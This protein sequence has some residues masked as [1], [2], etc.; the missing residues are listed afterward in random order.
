MPSPRETPVHPAVRALDLE[1]VTHEGTAGIVLHDR[2]G[3]SES[4][5]LPEELL[6]IVGR[7]DG[8]HT[9]QQI[10]DEASAQVGEEIPLEF[11]AGLVQQLD[12]RGLLL[13]PTYDGIALAAAERFLA[14]GE[15]PARHAGSAGYPRD[16]GA[17]RH[18]LDQLLPA[19]AGPSGP[20]RGL[21]APHIDLQRGAEG[22]AAA[23]R[24]LLAAPPAD[25]YVVFGTGH[26][27]PDAPVTGLPLDWQTP[28]GTVPT[29]REFV[30]AVHARIGTAAPIDLLH[31]RDEHS[32]EFQMLFLQHLHQRRG[33]ERPFAVAAFL[34]G[35]LPS[36]HGDPLAEDWCQDLLRAF[37]AAEAASG[38]TVC[39][40]AGADLAHIGPVFGDEAAVDQ[41]R[42]S[43]LA[44]IEQARLRHLQ[45][46]A[47]GAFHAAVDCDRNPDRIC[48]GPAITLCAALAG[49][50]GELL[51]Y[52][53][54]AA[55]DGSQ[56]VSF[57]A[58]AFAGG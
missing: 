52:G 11:V 53:Q 30:A 47:P 42:L 38:K 4:T 6:P 34:C 26:A 17:L 12:E 37:R 49:G 44:A 31:H 19:P 55:P 2:L 57:C 58:M 46:G 20:L 1:R 33:G 5:F 40:L 28:L 25:L 48:S 18:A 54:A 10:R 14:A 56:T 35:A 50:K 13:G 24:R 3:L 7:C 45:A 41:P 15:R 23:Y 9:V 27:G 36:T 16:Q 32:L 51:H 21:I 29:D 43:Q 8:S 39:Y 22:Y